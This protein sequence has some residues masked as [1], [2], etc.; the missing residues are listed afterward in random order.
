MFLVVTD[1]LLIVQAFM[2]FIIYTGSLLI[3]LLGTGLMVTNALKRDRTFFWTGAIILAAWLLF[4]TIA[5]F[6]RLYVQH[7]IAHLH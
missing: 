3:S 4:L 2:M 7:L 6:S 1:I 5:Y